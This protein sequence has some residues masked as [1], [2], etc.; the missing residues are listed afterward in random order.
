LAEVEA[1]ALDASAITKSFGVVRVLHD[2][3]VRVAPG[4]VRA[5]LGRGLREGRTASRALGYPQFVE[6]I[7][8]R[9]TTAEA[10]A[11]T[12]QATRRFVRRQRSW[13]RRDDRVRWLDASRPDLVEAV[14]AL[15]A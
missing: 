11:S 14:D 5:L 3:H 2:V 15:L 12:V 4:E 7:D 6:V 9:A 8:G 13:F 10:V 1:A